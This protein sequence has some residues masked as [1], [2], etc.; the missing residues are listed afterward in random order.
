[1]YESLTLLSTS[2]ALAR[3]AGAR[4]AQAAVDT[5]NADTPGFKAR[6]LPDFA[7]VVGGEPSMRR[8]RPGH[9]GEGPSGVARA[10]ASA[11]RLPPA[12]ARFS[13]TTV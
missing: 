10:T 7:G 12:P 3:H 13:T 8:T 9:M 6:A 1:M 4:Q 5:A 11:A 2:A